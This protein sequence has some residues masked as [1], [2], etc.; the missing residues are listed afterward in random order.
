M[1]A[2]VMAAGEG[3]R[4]RPLTERYAKPV[5][6]IDGRPVLA[7][8]LRELAA[9][10]VRRVWLVTGHLAE[11]VEALAGNGSAF[12]LELEVVAQPEPLGSADAVLRALRA[13]ARPPL[14]VAGADT[15]F[16]AGDVA[17][18]LAEAD[19]AAGA[20][21]VRRDPP[22]DPPHRHAIRVV[23][24]RVTRLL[25]DDAENP[26]AGAPLWLVGEAVA[27]RLDP[28]PGTAP[29]ELYMA[30]ELALEAGERIA[31]VEIGTT[32]DLTRPEDVVRENFPY[33]AGL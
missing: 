32:R 26:L 7:V 28:L 18:F 12:G 27:A 14:A 16:G 8:L 30:L 22:P 17:R 10:G 23:G 6:P 9:A 1:E 15:V 21:A 25:D 33:L 5:L 31:G 11:Q 3:R 2:V 4:L 29:H 19:G 24:G 13:G 20:V